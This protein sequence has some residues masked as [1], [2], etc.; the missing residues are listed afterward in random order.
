MSRDCVRVVVDLLK[1]L[2]T[3]DTEIVVL[4]AEFAFSISMLV[5]RFAP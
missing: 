3:L 2:V 4:K 5:Q 1:K